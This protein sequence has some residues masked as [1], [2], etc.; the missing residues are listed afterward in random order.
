MSQTSDVE[1]NRFVGGLAIEPP[2]DSSLSLYEI[3]DV[4]VR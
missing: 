1:N 4:F 3:L 2:L